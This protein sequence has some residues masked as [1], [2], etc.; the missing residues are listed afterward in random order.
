[1]VQRLC[2]NCLRDDLAQQS[3]ESSPVAAA[4]ADRLTR[5]VQPHTQSPD[6]HLAVG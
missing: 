1:M 3:A 4:I 5:W 6:G 2:A